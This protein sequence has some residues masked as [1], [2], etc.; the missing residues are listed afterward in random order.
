MSLRTI[1][2]A[3]LTLMIAGPYLNTSLSMATEA[4]LLQGCGYLVDGPAG[5]TLPPEPP[6]CTASL[7]CVSCRVTLPTFELPSSVLAVFPL[8]CPNVG[9][10]TDTAELGFAFTHAPGNYPCGGGPPP[11]PPAQC[12]FAEAMTNSVTATIQKSL[13]GIKASAVTKPAC[14]LSLIEAAKLGGFD[15]FNWYQEITRIQLPLNLPAAIFEYL[16]GR[17]LGVD[18][19]LGGNPHGPVRDLYQWY[20][21]EVLTGDRGYFI[22]SHFF[23]NEVDFEDYPNLVFAFTSIEFATYLVGVRE[24]HTGVRLSEL[25]IQGTAFRWRYTQTIPFVSQDIQLVTVQNNDPSKGGGG[26]LEL[27]GDIDPRTVTILVDVKPDDLLNS[28]NPTSKG[29]IPVAI[30]S[31]PVFDATSVDISTLRFGPGAAMPIANATDLTD[32]NGDGLIDVVVHVRTQDTRISCSDTSLSVTGNT[33]DARMLEG[34]DFIRTVG[35]S[36]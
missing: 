6:T 27:L 30:L 17:G 23:A 18:P 11:P 21:D 14:N 19:Q 8:T 16:A 7:Q 31:S 5:V 10:V 33:H 12:S 29:T 20:W 28:V 25:G 34:S 22:D 2:V 4:D 13:G 36:K 3:A 9:T 15:H 26:E 32:V 24:D 35:C 1:W